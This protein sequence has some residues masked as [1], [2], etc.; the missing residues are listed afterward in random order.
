MGFSLA[1]LFGFGKKA[2]PKPPPEPP[3]KAA[4]AAPGAA[5]Y[6]GQGVAALIR[7]Q[8]A[9]AA[10]GDALAAYAG[11]RALAEAYSSQGRMQ[12]SMRWAVEAGELAAAGAAA[13]ADARPVVARAA[14]AAA[15]KFVESGR[16]LAS[17]PHAG[18][19]TRVCGSRAAAL[20]ADH[21]AWLSGL[22]FSAGAAASEGDDEA[23]ELAA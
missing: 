6:G 1:A 15:L 2:E 11:A 16:P 7:T 10:R 22:G 20:M 12:L 13:A 3:R 19:L 5:R 17:G 23:G 4:P 18:V 14:A 21:G 8:A 9:A